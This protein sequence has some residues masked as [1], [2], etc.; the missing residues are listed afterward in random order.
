MNVQKFKP[1]LIFAGIMA[2]FVLLSL[3]YFSPVLKGFGLQQMDQT[4]A[5]GM[6][7]ELVEH[8]NATG[9]RA[10]WTNSMFGGMP[11]YQIRGDSSNNIFTDINKI[12]R[13]GLPYYTAAILFLYLVGFYVLLRSMKINRWLSL[14]G[15]VAFGFGSYN[16][17]IIMAG[18]ITKA[19]AIA[20][21]APVIAGILY[22]LNR[23]RWTGALFTTIALGLQIAYNHVQITYYLA[24]MVII[25][26]VSRLI[27]AWRD[28]Q[29]MDFVKRGM[30]LLGAAIIAI[31]PNLIHLWPTYEYG[32]Y[33]IRGPS[34]LESRRGSGQ[35]DA[36]LDRDYA[37]AWS[38]G[39]AETL[40]L[41]IPNVMGGASESLS[42][43]P[44]AMEEVDSR[45][46]R[47]VGGQSQY[48]GSKPFTSGP[49]YVGA[50]VCFLFVMALFFYKGREKWWLVAG[51]ILSIV[52]AWGQNLEWFNYWVFDF[53]PLYNKFRTVEM[54]LVIATVTIPLLG[55]LGLKRVMDN[56]ALIREQSGKFL[57]AFGLTGG[58]ALLLYLFPDVF[59]DFMSEREIAALTRQKQNMPEQAGAIDEVIRN[60]KQARIGLLKSDAV[61]SFFFILLGSGSLWL[62][63]TNRVSRKYILPGLALLV[64]VDLWAVDRRYLDNDDFVPPHQLEQSFEKSK[65]D[66]YIL[67]DD[68]PYFRVFSIY[69][70]PFNEVQTSYFHKSIGGYH[71]AKLG[72]YQNVIDHYLQ[73]NW[74]TLKGHFQNK[75]S[76]SEAREMLADM[77]VL[78]MLNTKYVIYNPGQQP[79]KNPYR[80]GNAW[81]VNRV[82]TV[83]SP[84]QELS[85]L[86][87]TDLKNTAIVLDKRAGE[88]ASYNNDEEGEISLTEY[89]P[90]RL[91][92]DAEVPAKK[93]AVFSDIFYPKGW[94]AY[95]DGSEAE[96]K[97]VNYILR[98]V[99]IPPGT[100][101]IEFRFEPNSVQAANFIGIIGG[102]IIVLFA[103]WLLFRYRKKQVKAH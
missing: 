10:H 7:Q 81:F 22:T 40:T 89:E 41:M 14:L 35:P 37:F 38:Y 69:Q 2:L 49:V 44:R 95:I 11:A 18:H 3:M 25:L 23:D 5:E 4:H 54:T 12:L 17:I 75:G 50:F 98:G 42:Q 46:H 58:V 72:I 6:A 96:I 28:G 51:T 83:P 62:Y 90:D 52:L 16:I 19:Y 15:A 21:M 87:D 60:M 34:E 57:A 8:E 99:M 48:W 59:F 85:S 30:I 32:Q 73:N 102:I 55:I 24:L 93:L 43:D 101:E 82:R 71:G 68:D 20:L 39:K 1:F 56:P 61:R 66:D 31:L 33:S 79:I 86:Q 9:E 97:R 47:I 65:A 91:S 53:L 80:Y 26:M 27:Y 92:F 76:V 78:N 45:L 84:R 67:Q 94:K 70:N 77:P 100:H 88:L 63:A 103:V 64:I 36:G 13:L 74:Q 29:L